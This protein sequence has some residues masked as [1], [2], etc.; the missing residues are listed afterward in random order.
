MTTIDIKIPHSLSPEE[1]LQRVQSTILKLRE[2]HSPA[3]KD[4]QEEWFGKD[5]RIQLSAKGFAVT[6]KI[7][8]GVDTVRVAIRLPLLLS[9]L[10]HRVKETIEKEGRQILNENATVA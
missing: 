2:Q 8:V 4:Y 3:I 5:G 9:F 6:G 1:A 7:Y 10:K